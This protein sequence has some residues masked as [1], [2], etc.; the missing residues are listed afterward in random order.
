MKKFLLIITL[1]C[2][3][4]SSAMA[5]GKLLKKDPNGYETVNGISMRNLWLL[6][7]FHYGVSELERDYEWCNVKARTATM[8]DGIKQE[9]LLVQSLM[10]S[11]MLKTYKTKLN[12]HFFIWRR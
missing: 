11:L 9:N 12:H 10:L 3:A 8:Q 4:C 6:D 2:L 7:R 5:G 1:V